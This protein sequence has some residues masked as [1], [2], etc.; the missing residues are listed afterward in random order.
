MSKK[1]A[2]KAIEDRQDANLNILSHL[3]ILARTCPDLRFGQ[4]LAMVDVVVVRQAAVGDPATGGLVVEAFWK[5]E[6]YLESVELE[7]RVLEAIRK[8]PK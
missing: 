7:K 4:L 6:F 1:E 3:A 2:M 8:L 5:N